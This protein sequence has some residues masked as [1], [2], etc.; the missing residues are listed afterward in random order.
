MAR[1][2]GRMRTQ[3]I[4]LQGGRQQGLPSSS[5]IAYSYLQLGTDGT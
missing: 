4:E 2:R 5:Q 3:R 1:Y